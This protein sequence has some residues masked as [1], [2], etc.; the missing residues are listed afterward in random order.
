MYHSCF[1]V[2]SIT[3]ILLIPLMVPTRLKNHILRK[4]RIGLLI[5]FMVSTLLASTPQEAIDGA[6][7]HPFGKAKIAFFTCE[8]LVNGKAKFCS[9]GYFASEKCLCTNANARATMAYCYHYAFPS[10]SDYLLDMCSNVYNVTL[11]ADD[12]QRSLEYYSKYARPLDVQHPKIVD[13]PIKLTS[14][15]IG[16]FKQSNDQYLGNYDRSVYYGGYLVLYWVIVFV[17]FGVV[18]WSKV[19]FPDFHKK[20]VDSF[21]NWFRKTIS[22]PASYGTNKTNHKPFLYFLD[23]LVPSR[24]ETVLLSGFIALAVY[25]QFVNIHYV[26]GDPLFPN[27]AR[28]LM[29]YN[30]VRAS[31]LT[32]SMMPFLIL[33]G[34][35]NNFLQWVTRWDY[36]TF[37]TLHRWISR[38]LVVLI[39][40][41][42]LCYLF[43]SKHELNKF[44]EDYIIYGSI[45]TLCGILIL[46][47]GLL[48]LRRKWYEVF[49]L[50]HIGLAFGFIF[51][52]YRHVEG[53]YCVW[54]YHFT[55]IVWISD[56]L[57]RI[58]RLWS[59]GFPKA[60][61]V[62][63]T[64]ETLKVIIPKPEF[65]ES[66]PGG[67]VFIHF[68]RPSCFWQSHPFTYTIS[69]DN[70]DEMVVYM[71]V[72]QGI[73]RD[74]YRYMAK[75]G[76][77]ETE[78]RVSVE[79]SYGE[80]TPASRYDTCIFVAGGNGIPGIYAE[81][82][83]LIRRQARNRKFNVKLIWVIR[84]YNSLHWFY[85]ELLSLKGT[86]IKTDIYIT[87]PRSIND[88]QEF[89]SRCTTTRS[90]AINSIQGTESIRLQSC[91]HKSYGSTNNSQI[92]DE[93]KSEL[94]FITFKEGR[95]DMEVIVKNGIKESPGSVA[96]V[97]CGHPVMVDD[98]R[99][100]VVNNIDNDE[101]KR[102]DYFE[103]LQVWS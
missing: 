22:L 94:S 103:Q 6:P 69:V 49:L 2:S 70:E 86:G 85:K 75:H 102:I 8:S 67:H 46:I 16:L 95:P 12:L 53:L 45:G 24:L 4:L 39:V 33:F 88:L 78:I 9:G 72:K 25:L 59:F 26:P 97:T 71:K 98:L 50:L 56:R 34:G 89:E 93:I 100:A 68:L 51:G 20:L 17:I 27:K 57:I 10:Y 43:Y 96:F 47:Q 44:W 7:F 21:S 15:E 36:S 61:V 101:T 76:V 31:I 79:G 14:T 37:I 29:K 65:W 60:R 74:L 52:A 80:T 38:L 41:H 19:I 30:A 32:S 62:L 42:S 55:F 11:T 83:D 28:A 48:V 40:V 81:A 99:Q 58:A 90:K 35:R 63:F 82:Y 23:L 3:L 66:I 84:E 13:H 54:F 91:M 1:Y 92:I 77:R 5:T 87:R 64:D 18:N 73:T